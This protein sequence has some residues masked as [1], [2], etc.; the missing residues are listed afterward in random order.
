MGNLE[1]TIYVP[2]QAH[3]YTQIFLKIILFII[4]CETKGANIDGAKED[5]VKVSWCFFLSLKVKR[6]FSSFKTQGIL[7]CTP[8]VHIP[9]VYFLMN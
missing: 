3:V 7:L 4:I 8:N 5:H 2:I 1:Q 6:C 9:N